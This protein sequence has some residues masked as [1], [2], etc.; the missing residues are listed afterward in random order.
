MNKLNESSEV[1][2]KMKEFL[3]F[4]NPEMRYK[5]IEYVYYDR[6]SQF[7]IFAQSEQHEIM[8]VAM[9]LKTRLN[10]FDEEIIT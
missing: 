1:H 6:I 2:P 7:N 4:V 9:R 3:D 8:Y 10:I 5:V